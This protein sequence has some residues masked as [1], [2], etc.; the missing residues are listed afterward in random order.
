MLRYATL[1]LLLLSGTFVYAQHIPGRY[2]PEGRKES[3]PYPKQD[4]DLYLDSNHRVELV[5]AARGEMTFKVGTWKMSGDTVMISLEKLKYLKRNQEIF[6]FEELLYVYKDGCLV[7][8]ET[9][10]R[11]YCRIS[12][13][14]WHEKD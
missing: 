13:K 3:Q 8:L 10:H 1:L 5:Q 6:W 14:V 2:A 4:L 11:K 12:E 7:P 9:Y